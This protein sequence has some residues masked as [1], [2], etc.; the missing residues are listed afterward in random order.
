MVKWNIFLPA[1]IIMALAALLVVAQAPKAQKSSEATQKTP[2]PVAAT[3]L[4]ATATAADVAAVTTDDLSAEASFE[5]SPPE[6]SA[7]LLTGD[8][9]SLKDV[10]QAYSTNQNDL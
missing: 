9:T 7:D 8:E 2:P 3:A 1:F 10:D 6:E 4:P 5:P